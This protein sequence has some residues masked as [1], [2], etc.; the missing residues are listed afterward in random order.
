MRHLLKRFSLIQLVGISSGVLLIFLVVLLAQNTGNLITKGNAITSDQNYVRI[1]DALEKIAHN[2][3]VERGLTAGFLGNPNPQSKA[4]V[5]AQREKADQAVQYLNTLVRELEINPP[6]LKVL[7]DLL[8]GKGAIRSEVDRENGAKAFAY[9][10]SLNQIAIET[11]IA[12]KNYV[13]NSELAENLSVAFLYAQY[14]ERL[15]QLRGKING[16]LAR[17]NLSPAVKTE[18]AFYI[19]Q[20]DLINRRLIAQLKSDNLAAYKQASQGDVSQDMQKIVNDLLSSPKPD[21]T[22]LPAPSVWFPL[23]TQQIGLIKKLLD[24]QWNTTINLGDDINSE[25]NSDILW[26]LV[27]FVVMISLIIVI[28]LHLVNTL[29]HEIHVLSTSLRKIADEGDLTLDVR[30]KTSDELGKISEATHT[31][32]FALRD[33]LLGMDSSIRANTRLSEQMNEAT[34]TITR[35]ASDTQKMATSI[36]SA[37]EEMALTSTEIA[38]A[39]ALSMQSTDELSKESKTLLA[40]ND[41]NYRSMS[42]LSEQMHK[43][44][45]E[46]GNME[47]QVAEINTILDSI[48]SVAEQTNLLALNAAIEAARAGEAGRGFAVVADEVRN[49]ANSSKQSSE[50]I[51]TLLLGLEKVSNEV[52]HEIRNSSGTVKNIM[53]DVAQT[54]KISDQATE[55][56]SDVEKQ[57]M[58]VASAAE[59]QSSTAE[60]IARDTEL[61][62]DVANRELETSYQLKAIFDDMML[63]G[64]TLHRTMN[65]FKFN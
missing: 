61:V 31:T 23:A 41:K 50:E 21:F 22:T 63:N 48:R 51:S 57:A 2:H 46:A 6:E 39:A 13:K 20:I 35:H 24:N 45:T 32:I 4:K 30:I 3:A 12:L 37:I 55:H 26:S 53:D 17:K 49:L 7:Q 9:Y 54:R 60:Q 47:K 5:D 16:T 42:D 44:E 19:G 25:I 56:S 27:F 34:D 64:E 59:Q 28:N 1:L 18:L 43:A 36:S 52:I 62:L 10:S 11:A 40:D 65:N 29:K 14:K 8:D 15:G 38:K 33:L 58:A